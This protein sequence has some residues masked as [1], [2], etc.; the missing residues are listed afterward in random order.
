MHWVLSI[1]AEAVTRFCCRA[2]GKDVGSWARGNPTKSG[3]ACHNWVVVPDT[4]KF[5]PFTWDD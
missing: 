5:Q 3:S 1:L 2:A 4:F